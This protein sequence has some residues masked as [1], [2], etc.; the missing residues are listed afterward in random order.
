MLILLLVRPAAAQWEEAI[1]LL[2]QGRGTAALER[3]SG[4]APE[5]RILRA[6]ALWQSRRYVEMERALTEL[7]EVKAAL[8]PS[9]FDFRLLKLRGHHHRLRGRWNAAVRYYQ[10]ALARTRS[11]GQKVEA[12]DALALVESLREDTVAAHRYLERGV[13]LVAAMESDSGLADH[14]VLVG[15][16]SEARGGRVE[17]MTSYASA[18]A[19]YRRLGM[20]NKMARACRRAS[21]STASIATCWPASLGARR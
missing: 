1:A 3:L 10:D 17:A 16:L 12:L 18:R 2:E 19:L 5:A 7:E 15:E 9:P 11:P 8:L 6:E 14:L 13:P 21:S 4:Q 20:P